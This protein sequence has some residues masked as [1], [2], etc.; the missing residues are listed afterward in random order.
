SV[1]TGAYSDLPPPTG[2]CDRP[3]LP[4]APM[5]R[6][7][8]VRFAEIAQLSLRSIVLPLPPHP[9][10][11][12]DARHACVRAYSSR[13]GPDSPSSAPFSRHSQTIAWLSGS[14]SPPH[15]SNPMSSRDQI[16]PHGA[17]WPFL[18]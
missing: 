5:P 16:T 17:E 9:S 18:V 6:I 11:S 15:A 12:T 4:V 14:H 8:I 10:D 1:C 13:A 3:G 7:A 2:L